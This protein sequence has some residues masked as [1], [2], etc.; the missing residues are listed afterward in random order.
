MKMEPAKS[1][2]SDKSLAALSLA[3]RHPETWPPGFVFDYLDRRTCAL[4]LAYR[5]EMI[6]EP[7]AQA[8][9]TAFGLSDHQAFTM[10]CFGYGCVK[11][12][13][14]TPE[15]VADRIDAH[16]AHLGASPLLGSAK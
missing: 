8:M 6:D 11:K 9:M 1:F 5:L 14:V 16:L 13:Q 3:L 15:M 7:H 4:G 12:G 2:A 10:F